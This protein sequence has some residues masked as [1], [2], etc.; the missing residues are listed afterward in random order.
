MMPPL[1]EAKMTFTGPMKKLDPRVFALGMAWPMAS[2]ANPN[3]LSKWSV[4][5]I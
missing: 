5:V 1:L 4:S 3:W 2:M